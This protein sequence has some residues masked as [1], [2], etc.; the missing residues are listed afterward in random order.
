MLPSRKRKEPTESLNLDPELT[1]EVRRE[2]IGILGVLKRWREDFADREFKTVDENLGRSSGYL[3]HVFSLRDTITLER[4]LAFLRLI[5]RS[6]RDLAQV[7]E[8]RQRVPPAPPAR[9]LAIAIQSSSRSFEDLSEWV[10]NLKVSESGGSINIGPQQVL[11]KAEEDRDLALEAIAKYLDLAMEFAP[12]SISPESANNLCWVLGIWS[13]ILKE[14]NRHGD[15]A[16]LLGMAF[17]LEARL[18][19]FD[20]RAFLYR[21]LAYVLAEI[22]SFHEAEECARSATELC[23]LSPVRKGL[24]ESLYA[25]ALILKWRGE[26]EDALA[27]LNGAA[28]WLEKGQEQ[29]QRAIDLESVWL[30]LAT[31]NLEGAI[32]GLEK[33]KQ[34]LDREIPN[35]DRGKIIF[36][37]AVVG[38]ESGEGLAA[39]R[40][41]SEAGLLIREFGSPTDQAL[42]LLR[43]CRHRLRYGKS[44]TDCVPELSSL[45][46]Y[47][48]KGSSGEA[49][50]LEISKMVVADEVSVDLLKRFIL[51]IDKPWAH[52]ERA[53]DGKS[54]TA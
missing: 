45:A 17:D 18:D 21:S 2:Y 49:A 24:G 13:F 51:V 38:S 44:L 40:D 50:L 27:F 7:L 1:E 19:Y 41:F 15:A 43:K 26:P 4:L 20:T 47:M 9:F 10:L 22:G 34:H 33:A 6:L 8:P 5:E 12:R 3:T 48:K 16:E 42:F 28:N 32:Q 11:E 52:R 37:R 35:L 46:N 39:D 54:R 25:R 30:K 31:G 53:Q 14:R 36:A 29:Y 23:L